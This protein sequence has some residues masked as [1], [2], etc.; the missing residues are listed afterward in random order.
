MKALCI[1]FQGKPF[2]YHQAVKEEL[3]KFQ[4]LEAGSPGF[5]PTIK[6]LMSNLS[7]H[8]KEEEEQDT[9]F[10]QQTERRRLSKHCEE[11]WSH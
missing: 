1:S 8:I 9:S 2:F 5:L 10:G 7:D 3:K 11:L 6:A 4:N